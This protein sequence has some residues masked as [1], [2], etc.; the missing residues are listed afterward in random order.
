MHPPSKTRGTT[1]KGLIE[2]PRA[3]RGAHERFVVEPGREQRRQHRVDRHQIETDGRP[4]VLSPRDKA[5]GEFSYRA[6]DVRFCAAAL[7]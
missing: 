1:D 6:G 2:H 5:F 4:A 3:A 7:T